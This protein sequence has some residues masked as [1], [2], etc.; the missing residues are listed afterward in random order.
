MAVSSADTRGVIVTS[1]TDA[2]TLAEDNILPVSAADCEREVTADRDAAFS[3]EVASAREA[4]T[5]PVELTETKDDADAEEDGVVDKHAFRVAVPLSVRGAVR[6][7][8]GVALD[9]NNTEAEG[10]DDGDADTLPSVECEEEEVTVAVAVCAI[11]TVEEGDNESPK[12][13]DA[14]EDTV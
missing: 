10:L 12:S 4:L 13:S 5:L 14:E 2:D 9:E 1:A 8:S 7:R 11:V 6:V 3:V